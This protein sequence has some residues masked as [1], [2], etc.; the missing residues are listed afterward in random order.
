[1]G[2]TLFRHVEEHP[3][4]G[5]EPITGAC[6]NRTV[7]GW[8]CGASTSLMVLRTNIDAYLLARLLP[9]S[10]EIH[11]P[12]FELVDQSSGK[13]ATFQVTS[14]VGEVRRWLF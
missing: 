3:A 14:R 1:M 9:P 12:R 13:M 5:F 4:L 8:R 6:Y 11:R 2:V 7:A 10:G